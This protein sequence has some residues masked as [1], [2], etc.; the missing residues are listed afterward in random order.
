MKLLSLVFSFKNEEKNLRELIER[1]ARVLKEIQ[2]WNY[3]LIF[4]NDN[5]SDNSQKIILELQKDHP[6]TLINLSRTFGRIPSVIAG[7]RKTKGNVVIYMDT[8]L[9]DPPEIIPE[10]L[11]KYE[12][13]S[14][15]VH[16]IRTRR[17][18][19]SSLKMV[20]TKFA[21]RIIN[22]FSDIPLEVNAGD[23]KLIS[24]KALDK[25]LEQKEFKPYVRGLS[26]WVGF[27]QSIVKYV[28]QPRYSGETKYPL[29]SFDPISEFVIGI[30]SY[31]NKPLFISILFSVLS[32]LISFF[33][34]IYALYAK[35]SGIAVPG[36]TSVIIAISFFS[37]I[38]L[39]SIGLTGIYIARIFDQTKGR[40]Q[41]VIKDIFEKE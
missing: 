12:Q 24:R 31:S 28:R 8:D 23:F 7:F 37:S 32:I 29:F 5:S 14:E 15:I 10:M 21:Y 33:L 4:V 2:N 26:V 22:F 6:I 1:T 34:V 20:I 27:K 3:E 25:I 19:E 41:Y 9:Q 13:G 11:E 18:G 16:T 30:T 38:I 40:D 39:F 36:T 35:F 17:L